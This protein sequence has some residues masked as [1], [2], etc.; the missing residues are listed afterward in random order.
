MDHPVSAFDWGCRAGS[1]TCGKAIAVRLRLDM[2]MAIE[3]IWMKQAGRLLLAFPPSE[4][5]VAGVAAERIVDLWPKWA[6]GRTLGRV[7]EPDWATGQRFPTSKKE[8]ETPPAGYWWSRARLAQLHRATARGANSRTWRAAR[9]LHCVIRASANGYIRTAQQIESAPKLLL[10]FPG[11]LGMAAQQV[12]GRIA[13][14]P[15]RRARAELSLAQAEA[16]IS[17]PRLIAEHSNLSALRLSDYPSLRVSE[18]P[19]FRISESLSRVSAYLP[20]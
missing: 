8:G 3:Y 19:S 1:D 15:R 14:A 13:N 11:E 10:L 20:F 18:L 2:A 16:T 9:T 4:A 6:A 12:C 5:S 17:L 7:V